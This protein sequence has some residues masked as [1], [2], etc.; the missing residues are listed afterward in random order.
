MADLKIAVPGLDYVSELTTTQFVIPAGASGAFAVSNNIAT[1]TTN[2]AH[3]L[4]YSPAAGTLANYFIQFATAATGITGVGVLLNNFF[5]ILSIP[6]T[7]TF[8]IYTTVTA[9]TLTSTTWNCVFMGTL[10]TS[11]LTTIALQPA[12]AYPLLGTVQELNCTFGANLLAQYNPDNTMTAQDPTTGATLA[13]AP[14]MRTLLAASSSGQI[15]LG[16][17]DILIASGTTATS[18][19]S[20]IE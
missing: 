1:I 2:A 4:T 15:R 20:I 8:T 5:R 19:V 11:L 7:T 14:T 3:G 17:Q 6:T 9:A 12:G 13:T 18:R 10:Q 16:P